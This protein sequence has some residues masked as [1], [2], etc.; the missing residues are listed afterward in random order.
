M[1]C[2]G[3]R[4]SVA[5]QPLGERS[6]D[7]GGEQVLEGLQQQS[8]GGGGAR[9][10][11]R[12]EGLAQGVEFDARWLSLR[13]DA[14]PRMGDAGQV[15]AALVQGGDTALAKHRH[16]GRLDAGKNTRNLA[17]DRHRVV[18][19]LELG[20]PYC[21]IR[22]SLLRFHGLRQVPPCAAYRA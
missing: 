18:E 14:Q 3:W 16:Q 11:V 22:T 2:G 13:W 17:R 5:Q 10:V 8:G 19:I 15:Q 1:R 9:L 20:R 6:T 7:E 12:Y 4:P 21:G